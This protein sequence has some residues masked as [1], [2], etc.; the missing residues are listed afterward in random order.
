M[1]VLVNNI[2]IKTLPLSR[3]KKNHLPAHPKVMFPLHLSNYV[4]ISQ[5]TIFCMLNLYI[6]LLNS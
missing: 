1:I 5:Y 3:L 4:F 2:N 6:T